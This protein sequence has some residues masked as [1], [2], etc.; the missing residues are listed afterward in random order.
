M[1]SL[2]GKTTLSVLLCQHSS[3]VAGAGGGK[4]WGL[5]APA[6]AGA[7][8]GWRTHPPKPLSAARPAALEAAAEQGAGRGTKNGAGRTLAVGVDRT[9][10]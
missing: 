6:E 7:R 8:L 9:S 10:N 5:S 3:K 4:P 1:S 2:C